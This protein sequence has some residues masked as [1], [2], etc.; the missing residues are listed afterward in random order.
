LPPGKASQLL[1]TPYCG[2]KDQFSELL[3]RNG[4]QSLVN[5]IPQDGR[6]TLSRV[7]V[8]PTLAA[9][10]P[11]THLQR[12][13]LRRDRQTSSNYNSEV[14]MRFAKTTVARPASTKKFA[15]RGKRSGEIV[16]TFTEMTM[17]GNAASA[18]VTVI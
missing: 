6:A 14:T 15:T 5:R 12:E 13:E 1:C 18:T 2:T 3:L 17:V 7:V 8:I 9:Y 10:A 4:D 11:G 16:E